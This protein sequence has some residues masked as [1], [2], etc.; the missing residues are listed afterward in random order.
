MCLSFSS[1]PRNRSKKVPGCSSCSQKIQ[2]I[3]MPQYRLIY[4]KNRGK[5]EV[6][7]MLFS[8]AGVEF[9]DKRIQYRGPESQE[10][11]E[12]KPKTLL[13]P[14]SCDHHV[15]FL[16]FQSYNDLRPSLV[17]NFYFTTSRSR[18]WWEGTEKTRR[19]QSGLKVVPRITNPL[20]SQILCTHPG[21]TSEISD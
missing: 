20:K 7:R 16:F 14:I 21:G 1:C 15:I 12:L 6:S 17:S 18:T 9:E 4:S 13:Y 19:P 8:L 3:T 2:V 5:A 11:A 10:W